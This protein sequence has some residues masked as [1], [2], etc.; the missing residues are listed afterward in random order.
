MR[1]KT[2]KMKETFR[3]GAGDPEDFYARAQSLIESAIEVLCNELDALKDGHL[4]KTEDGLR[5][6][7]IDGQISVEKFELE[8]T[9]AAPRAMGP[10]VAPITLA[11]NGSTPKSGDHGSRSP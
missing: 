3:P 4:D 2:P 7:A 5:A 6:Q 1:G 9:K 8:C 10:S 11:G